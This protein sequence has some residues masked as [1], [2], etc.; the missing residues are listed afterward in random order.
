MTVLPEAQ[1][2]ARLFCV[3][4]TYHKN[5]L[6]F[7]GTSDVI[8]QKD[9][10][11]LFMDSICDWARKCACV[12]SEDLDTKYCGK[13]MDEAV[14][15]KTS[16]ACF[17]GCLGLSSSRGNR[18]L[19]PIWNV[20]PILNVPQMF[21]NIYSSAPLYNLTSGAPGDNLTNLH[22]YGYLG[23]VGGDSRFK[24]RRFN[25]MDAPSFFKWNPI[26]DLLVARFKMIEWMK[27]F[28]FLCHSFPK[29]INKKRKRQ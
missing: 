8:L 28:Q 16:S 23:M 12:C 18:L 20:K 25:S 21:D 22:K 27:K 17:L 10:Y 13:H 29:T 6:T 3:N 14:F 4:H 11:Q 7:F 2:I 19:P 1:A 24:D 5:I 15:I 9:W 26:G